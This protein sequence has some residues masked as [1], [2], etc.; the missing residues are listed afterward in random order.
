MA[1]GPGQGRAQ[2]G[3]GFT[4]G[5]EHTRS[6]AL[7]GKLVRQLGERDVRTHR[8]ASG[9][10]PQRQRQ[11]CAQPRELRRRTGFGIDAGGAD[12]LAKQCDRL[13]RV[14]PAE[15]QRLRAAASDKIGHTATARHHRHAARRVGQQRVNLLVRMGVVQYHEDASA[16]EA[17]TG[18]AL[19]GARTPAGIIAADTPNESRNSSSARSGV[20]ARSGSWP[21]RSV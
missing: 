10:D 12:A 13:A 21:R 6:H 19:P 8:R 1:V 16:T 4:V 7:A 17:V 14:K 5:D 11:V 2:A 15:G 20:T 9:S 3:K 18:S